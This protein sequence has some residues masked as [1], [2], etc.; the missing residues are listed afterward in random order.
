MERLDSLRHSIPQR[1]TKC[2]PGL[3]NH[4]RTRLRLLVLRLRSVHSLSTERRRTDLEQNQDTADQRRSCCSG[5]RMVVELDDV[6]LS[7]YFVFVPRISNC[8]IAPSLHAPYSHKVIPQ[9]SASFFCSPHR[10][11]QGRLAGMPGRRGGI[12][13]SHKTL[14]TA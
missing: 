10:T 1:S 4:L 12:D 13:L 14:C 7:F 9:P 5:T 6:V 2:R 8:Y 3:H 11:A